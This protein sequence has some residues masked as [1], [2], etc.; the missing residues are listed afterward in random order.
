[1]G[2]TIT[3]DK[4][5]R[6]S[7]PRLDRVAARSTVPLSLSFVVAAGKTPFQICGRGL[8]S[9]VLSGRSIQT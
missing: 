7:R 5:F 2:R 9:G 1:M 6:I 4:P 3:P 8:P